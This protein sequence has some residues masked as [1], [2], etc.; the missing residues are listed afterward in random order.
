MTRGDWRDRDSSLVVFAESIRWLGVRWGM[1]RVHEGLRLA[2]FGGE[3][4]YWPW[5]R[6]WRG[7]LVLPA[8]MDRAMLEAQASRLAAFIVTRRR[9][10][11]DRPIHLMGY[12][13]GGY[14]TLRA[15]ELLPPD[16]PV[17]S[18][19]LL[20]A[21]VDPQHD[22]TRA[23]ASVR[24]RLVNVSSRLDFAILGLG[25][26]LFGNAE[27]LYRPSA[28]MTGLLHPSAL[29]GRVVQVRW[30]AELIGEGYLG[31]HFSVSAPR[32]IAHRVAPF[33]GLSGR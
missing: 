23:M 8:L 4:L 27:R 32:F 24:G 20:A 13:C 6:V 22:L 29:D 3:F 16:S 11:P 17:D 14:V 26:T 15:L 28:G 33:M 30:G 9:E 12:S 18:A 7:W 31:D 25:T 19:V 5:H 10:R 2:G 21:A 1:H